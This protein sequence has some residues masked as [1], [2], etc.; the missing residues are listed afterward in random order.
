MKGFSS[1]P[2]FVLIILILQLGVK[3][4][5]AQFPLL[6]NLVNI[7]EAAI[8]SSANIELIKIDNVNKE[9]EI[10]DN[11]ILKRSYTETELIEQKKLIEDVDSFNVYITR[12]GEE[13]RDFDI[14]TLSYFFLNNARISFYEY[15]KSLRVHQE[16]IQKTVRNIQEQQNFY[17]RN[18][19]KWEESIQS[20]EKSLSEPIKQHIRSNI[21][22]M[23]KI[24]DSYDLQI[25]DLVS[26]ENKVVHDIFYVDAILNDITHFSQKRKTELFRKNEKNIF[27]TTYRNSLGGSVGEKLKLA[28]HEN[29]KSLKY[30]FNTIRI[31]IIGYV[32]LIT[33]L[34]LILFFIRKNYMYIKPGEENIGYREIK[35]IVIDEPVLTSISIALFLWPVIMPYTPLFLSLTLFLATLILLWLILMPL[36]SSYV[37]RITLIVIIL[38]IISNF[39]NVAWYFGNYSRFYILFEAFAGMFLT[40]EYVLPGYR[41]KGI[42]VHNK[43]RIFYTRMITFLLFVLY[44]IALVSNITGYVNLSVYSL[45]IG[46]YT[47]V[48]S[49]LAINLVRI[50]DSVVEAGVDVMKIYY[51]DLV[52]KYGLLIVKKSKN[53]VRF[54]FVYF[55]ITGIL[56][57][58]EF[59][60][61]VMNK[62]G[63]VLTDK[64]KVGSISFTLANLILF[65][66]ILYLTYNI[67]KFIKLILER[68]ILAKQSRKRGFAASISLTLR[69][70]VVFLG[71]LI[72][73]SFSGMDLGK[74]SII[75]GAL[76]VG[77]GFGLQNVVSNFISGLIL[78]Y[79]KPV[80]EGDV[81][82][83]GTLLG[84]VSNIGIRSSTVS[85]YEGAEVVVPNSNLI[86]NELINWTLSNSQKRVEIKVATAYGT[87]PR[88]VLN[89]LMEAALSHENVLRFPEPRPL[90]LGFGDS[91]LDFRLLFWV[92][93]ELGLQTQSDVAVKIYEIFRE[94]NIE[95]PFPQLD[96]HIKKPKSEIPEDDIQSE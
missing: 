81:V 34:V 47:A 72:A 58:A 38:L 40:Y 77:I 64:I 87:D 31:N 12:H 3:T 46:V 13:F 71:T 36:M 41:I 67:A 11:L 74:V 93:F 70:I 23:N 44:S 4:G 43:T 26:A 96:L 79:E 7:R 48:Y 88:K 10:T 37:K 80:Q 68:E 35:R 9:I 63:S 59:Y 60:M 50:N 24:I 27:Q 6:D 33:I 75:A 82:E 55:L 69:I 21:L 16:K 91:S 84:K 45:K 61:V 1:V 17:I 76:S 90:F 20:L 30:F 92:S 89:L 5:S 39:E 57:V 32:L 8:D 19:Q 54:L 14:S 52:K 94:N 51:P 65:I 15:Y 62:I 95:I 66:L 49:L 53:A 85:T 29:T 28:Y 42:E 25:K 78:I 18:K 56:R 2:K 73:L 86:S 83:V 22:K